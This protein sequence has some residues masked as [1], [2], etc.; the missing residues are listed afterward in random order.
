MLVDDNAVVGTAER[1][2]ALVTTKRIKYMK[3]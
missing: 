1:I 2:V 3:I